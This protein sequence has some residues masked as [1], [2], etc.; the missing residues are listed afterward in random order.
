MPIKMGSGLFTTEFTGDKVFWL[1]IEE[2]G[3][4]VKRWVTSPE[5][6]NKYHF[7]WDNIKPVYGFFANAIPDG[8]E[9]VR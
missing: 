6:M 7:N 3:R 8:R 2:T 1:D 9:V 5:A 4:V